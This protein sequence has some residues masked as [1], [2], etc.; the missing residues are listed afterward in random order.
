MV[1]VLETWKPFAYSG[2]ERGKGKD[3]STSKYFIAFGAMS[4][5]INDMSATSVHIWRFVPEPCGHFTNGMNSVDGPL[6]ISLPEYRDVPRNYSS[7]NDLAQ[8]DNHP[9][10]HSKIKIKN[11][12]T[13]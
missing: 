4:A 12:A 9:A 3:R 11:P 2:A 6:G 10:S 5:A 1:G 8:S 13:T 7:M